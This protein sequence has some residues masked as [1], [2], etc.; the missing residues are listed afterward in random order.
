MKPESQGWNFSLAKL[1]PTELH[2]P[3]GYSRDSIEE[4]KPKTALDKRTI[5]EKVS[6]EQLRN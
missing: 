5:L 6:L 1:K 2:P 4:T 3:F